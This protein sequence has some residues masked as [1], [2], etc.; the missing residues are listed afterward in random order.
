[1]RSQKVSVGVPVEGT[2]TV[3]L[4]VSVVAEPLPPSQSFQEPVRAGRPVLLVIGPE[5][6]VQLTAAGLEA[7]VEQQVVPVGGVVVGVP[8]G[9]RVGVDVE[10]VAVP[11]ATDSADH[12]AATPA[13]WVLLAPYRSM[14]A[15][16][17]LLRAIG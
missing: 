1:M 16:M 17:V 11:A 12:A 3:W 6:P 13:H 5:V 4:T 2:A 7:G 9:V 15:L 10:H 8:V 14:A